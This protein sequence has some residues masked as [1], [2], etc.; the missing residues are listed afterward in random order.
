MGIPAT[1]AQL[2]TPP[3]AA[4]S[5][6][7]ETF[8]AKALGT[9]TN[10][11]LTT[12]PFSLAG[13]ASLVIDPTG[14]A[15][16]ELDGANGLVMGVGGAGGRSLPYNGTYKEPGVLLKIADTVPDWDPDVDEIALQ[17][18]QTESITTNDG[19]GVGIVPSNAPTGTD[20]TFLSH[21]NGT[22]KYYAIGNTARPATAITAGTFIELILG[23]KNKLDLRIGAWPGDWPDPRAWTAEYEASRTP[24]GTATGELI[25]AASTRWT[26]ANAHWALLAFKNAASGSFSGT[27]RGIRALRRPRSGE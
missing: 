24:P 10:D 17:V 20:F 25:D 4:A 6:W 18:R 27:F 5:A 1:P 2:A 16:C 7:V 8:D 12:S 15:Q 9:F 13:V 19:I 14:F 3:A 22:S 26:A 11:Y 21:L 23:P